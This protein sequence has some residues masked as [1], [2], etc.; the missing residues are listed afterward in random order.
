MDFGKSA[1][2]GQ[3]QSQVL[4]VSV[5]YA[6]EVDADPEIALILER[7]VRTGDTHSL[8]CNLRFLTD[9]EQRTRDTGS[10]HFRMITAWKRELSSQD[11]SNAAANLLMPTLRLWGAGDGDDGVY[12]AIV[13]LH[14]GNA[15]GVD[16]G[17]SLVDGGTTSPANDSIDLDQSAVTALYELRLVVES[18]PMSEWMYMELARALGGEAYVVRTDAAV[19]PAMSLEEYLVGGR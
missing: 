10:D 11:S 1:D 14:K 18:L 3:S 12:D 16:T 8:E 4:R 19:Y 13:E 9:L 6:I 5:S 15:S 7:N 17:A 2:V